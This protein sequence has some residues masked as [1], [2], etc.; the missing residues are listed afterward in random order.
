M[1]ASTALFARY[2]FNNRCRQ[3]YEEIFRL[4]FQDAR[5]LLSTERSEN[6]ENLIPVLFENYIDFLTILIGEE[7]NQYIQLKGNCQERIRL[8]EKGNRNSPYYLFSLAQVNL[9]W[10]FARIKFGDYLRAAYEIQKSYRLLKENQAKF[11]GFKPNLLGMGMLHVIVGSVPDNYQWVTG[12][13][14]M[15]GSIQQGVKEISDYIEWSEKQ[16]DDFLV[17]EAM[18]FLSFVN[19]NFSVDRSKGIPLEDKLRSMAPES[20]LMTFAYG[21]MLIK[22]GRND[23]AILLFLNR[24]SDEKQFA[25]YYLDYLTGLCMLHKLD[26]EC[27]PYFYRFVS[28]FRGMNYIREA[29][30]KLA[31]SYILEEDTV[32]YLACMDKVMKYGS[33]VT[34]EDKIAIKEAESG[35]IPNIILLRAR[36]LFDGAYYALAENELLDSGSFLNNALDSTEYFYR[37]GRIYDASGRFGSAS[38]YYLKTIERGGDLK[39]YFAAN[40]A[41]NLGIIYENEGNVKEAEKYYRLCR[42]LDFDEYETGIKQKAKAGLNRLSEKN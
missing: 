14:S 6:P 34:D 40:A 10:A 15:E 30:Q 32:N 17:P 16:N 13:F 8:L 38:N 20:P 36:L 26:V 7:E 21:R 2:D 18:F 3:A 12:L 1:L 39:R 29:W 5:D 28:N 33:S 22:H 27:R 19:V 42:S 9:Q 35:Y 4:H 31:W 24:T 37:L 25:F 11:P 41:L 23:D